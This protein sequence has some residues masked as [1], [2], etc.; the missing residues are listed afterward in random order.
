MRAFH[1]N[2]DALEEQ[3]A[4]LI[5]KWKDVRKLNIALNKRNKQLEKELVAN[6]SELDSDNMDSV[7]AEEHKISIDLSQIQ[8]TIN[9]QIQKIDNCIELINKELD[10]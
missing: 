10:G 2:I 9:Q 8:E 5:Q 3:T 1:S 4:Q 6:K 7:Q